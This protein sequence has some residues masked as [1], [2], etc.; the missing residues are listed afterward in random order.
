MD[1]G[2]LAVEI[3]HEGYNCAQ[4]VLLAFAEECGISRDV[5]AKV[6]SSFGGGIGR[7]REVCGAVSGMCMAAGLAKGYS[8][9]GDVQGRAEHYARIQQMA[10]EFREKFG[11]IICRELLSG[12]QVTTGGA[13][14]ERTPEYY[15]K[16]N[17][18]DCVRTAAEIAQK[19]LCE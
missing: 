9:A 15:K 8:D 19:Y 17:C 12:V 14:E 6:A 16:R 5:A 11:S 18:D 13:P 1:K 10:G 2:Q 4:A 3:F 7:L